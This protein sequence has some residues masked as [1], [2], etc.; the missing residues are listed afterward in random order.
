MRSIPFRMVCLLGMNDGDFP[1]SRP[2]VDF[3]LMAHDHRS[4]DRSRRDDDR[5]LFL[6]ALL[7]ARE[8]LHISW[9]GKSIQ[10]NS[11]R[12]PSVLVSQLR[13]HIETCWRLADPNQKL[14]PAL[15]VEHK[16]QAF[17]R[18]YFGNTDASPFFTYAKEWERKA[19]GK[20]TDDPRSEPLTPPTLQVPITLSQLAAFLKDPVKTFFQERLRVFYAADEQTSQDQEPFQLDGLE[21]WT[22]QNQLIQARLDAL[23]HGQQEAE[24]VERQLARIRRSGELPLGKLADLTE[25]VLEEPLDPMFKLY[26]EAKAS[27]PLVLED[28]TFKYSLKFGDQEVHVQD[29]IGDLYG[30]GGARCRIELNASDLFYQNNLRHDKLLGAWVLHLASHASGQAIT[31]EVIGKNGKVTIKSLDQQTA[32]KNFD[33]LVDA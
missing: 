19:D 10:D 1:R 20:Q 30:S 9:V 4:G 17:S 5:Y 13:D 22:L 11:D 29:T 15:T 25:Q 2:P 18:D 8:K 28:W 7:S 12:P 24:S 27:W 32:C 33:A 31:T 21:Q 26:G 16:L 6:E 14:L 23:V 3:D